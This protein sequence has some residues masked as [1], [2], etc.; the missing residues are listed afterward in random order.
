MRAVKLGVITAIL[1]L[2]TACAG[3]YRSYIEMYKFV[4]NPAQDAVLTYEQVTTTGHDFL[5]VRNGE[6]PRAVL[7]LRFIEQQQ[8]KWLAGDNAMLVT[9]GGRVTKTLGLENDL[10]YVSNLISDPLPQAQTAAGLGINSLNNARWLR[11][12]DWQSGEY[13]LVIESRFTVIPNQSLTF[14]DQAITVHKVIETLTV[15]DKPTYW[16]FDGTWQNIF[17]LDAATGRV[18]QS[19]QQLTPAAQP[20]ELIFISEVARQ[21]QRAGIQIAAEAI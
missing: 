20:I 21:F 12:T 19:H 3:T 4:L 17:W 6:R 15:Q 2:L 5:Y 8:L 11:A 1:L 18:L 16:R 14:F 9:Q 13:G 10:L 7:G